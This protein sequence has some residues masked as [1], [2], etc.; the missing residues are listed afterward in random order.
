MGGR[1]AHSVAGCQGGYTM[2]LITRGDLDGLTC[3]VLITSMEQIDSIEF[4]HPKDM[5]DGKVDVT[6]DDI[7]T[8][9]PY[10]PNC[11]MWFDHHFGYEAE[12]MTGKFKGRYGVAPSA[13][14]LVFEY[15]DNPN[16]ERF[17]ELVSETDRV[18]SAQLTMEDITNPKRYV[19]LS[20]TLDPRTGLGA[21]RSYFMHLL[22]WLKVHP[23]N[24]IL[25]FPEVKERVDTLQKSETEYRR[26]L[27]KHCV[28]DGNVVHIDFRRLKERPVGNRFLVYAL[29]PQA[30]VS[31][32][33]FKGRGGENVVAAL[34]HSILNRSCNTNVGSLCRTY[35]GGGHRG[36]ATCQLEKKNSAKQ[37]KEII[38]TL[39]ANG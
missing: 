39:K 23:I 36:A 37:I 28:L 30:N 13:A 15:Y 25:E 21:F 4:A 24:D 22:N 14:R 5:Q 33:T 8:N 19:L 2:R 3:A 26:A 12:E 11:A 31:V 9:L 17:G 38:E 34:G 6:G 27:K 10:H 16:L 35:G 20:H 29:F 18:D 7:I 1:F 32:Q